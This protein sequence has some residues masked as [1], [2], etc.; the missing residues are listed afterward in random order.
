VDPDG[1]N[2]NDSLTTHAEWAAN[3]SNNL[4][5]TPNVNYQDN[6]QALAQPSLSVSPPGFVAGSGGYYS[7]TANYNFGATITAPTAGVP[8]GAGTYVIVQSFAN[9]GVNGN[10]LTISVA[11]NDASNAAIPGVVPIGSTVY[12]FQ[13]NYPTLFGPL[14]VA[15]VKYE[16][17]IP[18]YT[19]D[20]NLALTESQHSSL[21]GLRIDTMLSL[22]G[23]GDTA[24][25][26]PTAA[27]EPASLGVL[28]AGGIG[29]LMRRRSSTR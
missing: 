22:P 27:P 26:A 23:A 25:F 6:S 17:W 14:D 10:G 21:M 2:I 19:G 3:L 16:F 24:P 13:S 7:P 4:N 8:V 18:N 11:L 15:A 28:A 5:G 29:L 20:I 1:W 9:I 12:G